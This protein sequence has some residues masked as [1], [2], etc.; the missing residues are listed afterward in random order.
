[1]LKFL[2]ITEIFSRKE[3]VFKIRMQISAGGVPAFL[4]SILVVEVQVTGNWP[5][6]DSG[7]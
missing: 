6:H 7:G 4:P 3:R 2:T 1:M 5:C